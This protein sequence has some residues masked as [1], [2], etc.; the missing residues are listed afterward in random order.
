M[1][2]LAPPRRIPVAVPAAIALAWV[3]ALAAEAGGTAS[4]LHHDDLAEGGLPRWAALGL[5]LLSWQLMTAAMM[6]PSSL[7]L[8]R[9]FWAA[10]GRRE[11][12]ATFLGGYAVVWSVFGL[13]AFAGDMLLH[14]LVHALPALEARPWLI[15]GG[16]LVTAGAFQFSALKDACLDECRH[17]AV[18]LMREYRRGT[19]AAFRLGRDHGVFC[20][21]CC[22]ALMLVMFAAGFANLAWMAV[23][24]A[25]MAYEKIGRHGRALTPVL[26]LALAGW[27]AV[28]LAHPAWLPPALGGP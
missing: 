24:A 20:L 21:G 26:G 16:V 15:A 22:W 28:V 17:P 5:F 13:A 12:L 7:P 4:A 10:S 23:L 9:L 27:G 18:F 3:V 6:L 14:E 2:A 8:V 1:T 11:A 19:G 25:V